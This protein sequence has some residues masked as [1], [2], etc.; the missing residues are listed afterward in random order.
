MEKK[1]LRVI[2]VSER[3]GKK[4]GSRERQQSAPQHLSFPSLHDF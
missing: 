1:C 3:C 4:E 2:Y